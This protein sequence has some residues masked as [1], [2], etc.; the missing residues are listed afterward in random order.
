MTA[1]HDDVEAIVK[2]LRELVNLFTMMEELVVEQDCGIAES[3]ERSR[4]VQNS[5]AK[6]TQ[7]MNQ[8]VDKSRGARKKKWICVWLAGACFAVLPPLQEY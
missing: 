2:Q 3:E 5:V 7:E 6:G 1:R 8:A 4:E